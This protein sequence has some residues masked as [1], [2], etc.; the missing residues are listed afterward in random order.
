MQKVLCRNL[1][2][3][4]LPDVIRKIILERFPVMSIIGFLTTITFV[5][6]I[7]PHENRISDIEPDLFYEVL[8]QCRDM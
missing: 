7:L 8:E 5:L 1:N 2:V 4:W 3:I 6:L